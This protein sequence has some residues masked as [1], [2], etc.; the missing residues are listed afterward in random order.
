MPDVN[1]LLKTILDCGLTE[2]QRLKES[3][4]AMPS[5]LRNDAQAV[6]E[7]LVRAGLLTQF[8]ALRLLNERRPGLNL[9]PYVLHE[10]I[11]KGGMCR[12]FLARDTRTQQMVALKVLPPK[13]A[14]ED[15]RILVRFQR[16]IRMIER[17]SHPHIACR[18]DAG[19]VRGI[20]YLALEFVPGKSLYR[21]VKASGPL[22]L[23]AA[24]RLFVQVADALEYA[25]GLSLVHRDLKPSNIMVTPEGFAKMLD[26]GLALQMGE[27]ELV[28]VIGGRGY[29]VG[30]MDYISPEQAVDSYLVDE[31]S[32]LYSVG[33]ALY[34]A[35]CG[36]PPFPGGTKRDKIQQHL[37]AEPTPLGRLAPAL[38]AEFASIVATLMAKNPQDRYPSARVLREVLERWTVENPW[39]GLGT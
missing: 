12:V 1:A 13:R 8:Q 3:L 28:E 31:R 16:E 21:L 36:Q 18:H 14:R 11:G 35:L 29:A 23:Q 19:E 24:A 39:R 2:R 15:E 22:G 17:L 20:H 4:L 9:G 10:P 6:A 38:P 27:L 25:H 7:H 37:R 33:C 5:E 34:F 32:D 26:F 30:T